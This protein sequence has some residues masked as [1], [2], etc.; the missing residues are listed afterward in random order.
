MFKRMLAGLAAILC[1][2]A[3]AFGANLPLLT[4]PQP[5]ADLVSIINTLIRSINSGVSGILA[6]NLTAASTGAD[7]TEDV[8]QTYSLPANTLGTNGQG[9][10]VVCWG[11]TGASSNNKTIKL[12]FGA[13]S[14]S[15]GTYAGNA[16]T[17]VLRL[18]VLRTGAATQIVEGDGVAGTSSV[19]PV[20][21]YNNAS[22]TDNLAAAVTI[23][24][25][26][27]NGTASAADITATGMLVE[28]IR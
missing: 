27:Q 4:G 13:S 10:R 6:T 21:V 23:K 15:T 7:V 9:V 25:T 5:A 26:G 14:I 17:W 22:G 20:A 24:C 3:I 18:L 19:T 11:S 28:S 2:G 8:L 1:A 16:Q 12:Y